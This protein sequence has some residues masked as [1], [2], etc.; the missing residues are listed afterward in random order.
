PVRAPSLAEVFPPDGT[1]C[2]LGSCTPMTISMIPGLESAPTTNERLLSWVTEVAALTQPERVVWCDG[3]PA[4]WDRLTGELVAGGTLTRLDP[5]RKPNSFWCA[6]D[7]GDVARVEDRT[8]ICSVDSRDAGPTNNWMAP[9][10]MKAV[11]IE[12]YRGSMRG[13]TMYVIPFCMGPLTA[14]RPKLGVEITDS[15]YVVVS[16]HIMTR[17]GTGALRRLEETGDFVAGLH[18]VGAPLAPGE[19]DVPWP[20]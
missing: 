18:S 4:E 16:T 5:V 10:T 2:S 13:R 1:S 3:S 9:E 17:M 8:Y 15:A 14:E 20:C 7:P 6:S 11:M 12:L 19:P